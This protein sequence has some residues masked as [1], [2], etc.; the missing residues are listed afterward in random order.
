MHVAWQASRHYTELI[1]WQLADAIRSKT[2][3][4][5]AR[6]VFVEDLKLHSQTEDAAGSICRNIAE[7]FGCDS[8]VEFARYL[9][10]SRRSLNELLDCLRDAHL[11]GYI[12]ATDAAPIRALARRLFPALASLRR[13]LKSTPSPAHGSARHRR[14]SS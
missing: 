7:G 12:V 3:P 6:S 14:T 4:L 5:T 2:Y 8:H 1:V 10:I 13:H 11:K 9:E